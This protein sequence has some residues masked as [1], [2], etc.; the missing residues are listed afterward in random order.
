MVMSVCLSVRLSVCRLKRI[1]MAARAYH[2]GRSDRTD[3]FAYFRGIL[4][5]RL[6]LSSL[7]LV[8]D[9]LVGLCEIVRQ[10]T[11]CE[12]LCVAASVS[13]FIT[14]TIPLRISLLPIWMTALFAA[15]LSNDQHVLRCI[16]P[17]RNTH[18]YSPGLGAMNLC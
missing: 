18:S 5:R 14:K 15:V 9:C 6:K 1:R 3:L 12:V 7:G 11:T 4:T 17:E 10:T 16:L 13:I 8:C 2:V